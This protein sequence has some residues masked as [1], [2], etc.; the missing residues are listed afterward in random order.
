MSLAAATSLAA[1]LSND[2]QLF[3]GIAE[4][5][6]TTMHSDLTEDQA[7]ENTS[8]NVAASQMRNAL[9]KL[10]D[11]VTNPEEKKVRILNPLVEGSLALSFQATASRY[12]VYRKSLC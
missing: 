10:A 9:N 8:T 4:S 6:L 2:K 7:F 5:K 3:D 11:T 12:L 1:A